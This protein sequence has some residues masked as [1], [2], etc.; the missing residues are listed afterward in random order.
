MPRSQ[1]T[2]LILN[3]FYTWCLVYI[4][5]QV[6]HLFPSFFAGKICMS[7]FLIM[8]TMFPNL[9]KKYNHANFTLSS[10]CPYFQT[11]HIHI[12]QSFPF[13]RLLFNKIINM[14]KKQHDLVEGSCSMKLFSSTT[15]LQQVSAPFG[16]TGQLV[17]TV[18]VFIWFHFNLAMF[19]CIPSLFQFL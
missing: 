9:L 11:D 6:S 12:M 3:W 7:R 14:F 1:N 4:Y 15:C 5:S 8:I 2:T 10:Q 16:A 19:F 18:H 17:L 13:P